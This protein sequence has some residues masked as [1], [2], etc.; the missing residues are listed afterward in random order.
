[1]V[2]RYDLEE[3]QG[4]LYGLQSAIE[5]VDS[6]LKDSDGAADAYRE[7]FD[8]LRSATEPLASFWLEPKAVHAASKLAPP[9]DSTA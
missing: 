1:M 5:D 8:W 4:L 6:D 3:L 2:S 7:A 9:T